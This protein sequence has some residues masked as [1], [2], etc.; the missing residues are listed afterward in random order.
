M[1]NGAWL[2]I[3]PY[4]WSPNSV[5]SIIMTP[6]VPNSDS[7]PLWSVIVSPRRMRS[8]VGA[9]PSGVYVKLRSGI[10]F[11]NGI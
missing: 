7:T 8:E 5:G 11:A 9:V 3:M 2:D 10:I 1:D 4:G 6:N